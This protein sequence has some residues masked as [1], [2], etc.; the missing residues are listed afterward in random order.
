VHLV[1]DDMPDLAE[2]YRVDDFV[3]TVLFVPIKIF[4]LPTMAYVESVL[5]R[6]GSETKLPE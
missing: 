3:V 2:I 4:G 5:S 6:L 1:V